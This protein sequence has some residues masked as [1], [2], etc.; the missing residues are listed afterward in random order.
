MNGENNHIFHTSALDG[1][2]VE[3]RRPR[4][5]LPLFVA[6]LWILAAYVGVALVG[7]A[8]NLLSG[9]ASEGPPAVAL[10]LG[11]IGVVLVPVAW[12]NVARQLDRADRES[13]PA[14]DEPAPLAGVSRIVSAKPLLL[15]PHR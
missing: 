3:M 7:I 1:K 6:Q 11:L 2:P 12:R 9:G 15:A 8:A 4:F 10:A 5:T 14:V 13:L